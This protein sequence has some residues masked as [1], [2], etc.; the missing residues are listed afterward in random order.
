MVSKVPIPLKVDSI[1][2]LN[3][4]VYYTELGEGMDEPGTVHFSIINAWVANVTSIP[5]YQEKYGEF[6]A[7]ISASINQNASM[8]VALDV[9]YQQDVF[10]LNAVISSLDLSTLNQTV[11]PLAGIE[12]KSGL[13]HNIDLKMNA[14]SSQ[15]SNVLQI[16]YDSLSLSVVKDQ[17][18]QHHT[19][20][21]IS[22]IANSA[23][24]RHNMPDKGRYVV[25]EFESFRNIHRGPFNFM[26]ESVKEGM[27]YIIPTNASGIL[28]G[29]PEKKAEK[30]L[31]KQE[32][33]NNHSKR[34]KKA[35]A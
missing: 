18:H 14:T 13:A 28:L 24:R 10:N 8:Q 20:S 19:K 29:N 1:L 17:E 7:R 32:E 33:K 15:S 5:E 2:I 27:L 35:N 3:S 11:T 22:F 16:D 23:I 6:Q 31:D 12:V 26:W 34:K 9:P 25:A 30:S 21:L 4:D